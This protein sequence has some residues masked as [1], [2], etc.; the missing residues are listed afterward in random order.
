MSIEKKLGMLKPFLKEGVE[1]KFKEFRGWQELVLVS[2][3][4]SV[5]LTATGDEGGYY[6]FKDRAPDWASKP[7]DPSDYLPLVEPKEG[8]SFFMRNG[9][10]TGPLTVKDYFGK[11]KGHFTDSNDGSVRHS[12]LPSGKRKTMHGTDEP[13]EFDLIELVQSKVFSL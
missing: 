8:C 7:A 4:Q 10:M 11:A 13:N 2:G 12:W 1:V 9:E 6:N 3:G 5:T